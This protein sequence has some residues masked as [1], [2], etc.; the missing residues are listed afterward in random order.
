MNLREDYLVLLRALRARVK[1]P[2]KIRVPC[3][4]SRTE[5]PK[6]NSV[7]SVRKRQLPPDFP[8]AIVALVLGNGDNLAGKS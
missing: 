1:V 8:L 5:L 2:N 7:R 6:P 4:H 3:V